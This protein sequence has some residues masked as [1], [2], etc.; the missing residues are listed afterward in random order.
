MVLACVALMISS[1]IGGFSQNVA[2]YVVAAVALGGYFA[3]SSGTV[4]SIVYDTVLE[5]TGSRELYETWIGRCRGASSAS[6]VEVTRAIH[7][8]RRRVLDRPGTKSGRAGSGSRRSSSL[9]RPLQRLK[10]QGWR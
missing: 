10:G 7:D 5:E 8:D 1:T 6:G 4:D 2:T 9:A 3:L